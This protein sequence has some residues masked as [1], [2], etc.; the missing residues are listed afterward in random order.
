MPIDAKRTP[1]SYLHRRNRGRQ[2]DSPKVLQILVRLLRNKILAL[3]INR[4]NA[5]NIITGHFAQDTEMFNPGVTH[6]DIQTAEFTLDGLEHGAHFGLVG[7]IGFHGESADAVGADL[8]G[9]RVSCRG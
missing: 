1:I 5:V 8:V 7:D 6:D 9:D 4:K 3:D 2:H